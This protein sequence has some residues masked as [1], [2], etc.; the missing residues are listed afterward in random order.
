MTRNQK[1]NINYFLSSKPNTKLE[2]YEELKIITYDPFNVA[3]FIKR[4]SKPFFHYKFND[5][6][7]RR[8][9]INTQKR[10]EDKRI[11]SLSDQVKKGLEQAKKFQKDTILYCSWGYE[12]T[13]IDFYIIIERKGQFVTLQEISQDKSYS[14]YD[15]GT[16]TADPSIKIGEPFR[17]KISKYGHIKLN[18]YSVCS[19]WDGKPM[20]W[21]AYA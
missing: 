4:R 21:T 8:E 18:T 3:I 17:K 1:D 6:L 11:K 9:W 16:C 15:Q 10:Y 5:E 7:G 2:L 19:L 20:I 13:N 12:Q 14:N